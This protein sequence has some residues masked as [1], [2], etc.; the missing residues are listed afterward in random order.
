MQ[1]VLGTD[2]KALEHSDA[3]VGAI[4]AHHLSVTLDPEV[5]C[6][7]SAVSIGMS[8]KRGQTSIPSSLARPM[9]CDGTQ[10]A[11]VSLTSKRLSQ[12]LSRPA[13]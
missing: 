11:I 13:A 2:K 3:L 12:I 6:S 10:P 5:S 4:A 1:S 7:S 9:K 8:R